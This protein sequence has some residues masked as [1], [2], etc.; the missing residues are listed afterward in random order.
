[1]D[2][3]H[4][5]KEDELVNKALAS[6]LER[7]TQ[8]TQE[9]WDACGISQLRITHFIKAGERYF[10]PA[11]EPWADLPPFEIAVM[12]MATGPDPMLSNS[13]K[14]VSAHF[15]KGAEAAAATKRSL[16]YPRAKAAFGK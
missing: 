14:T 8:L 2:L 13:K 1:M 4:N 6:A 10:Q 11:K 9:E 16:T 5:D 15:A 12:T 7:K 3:E